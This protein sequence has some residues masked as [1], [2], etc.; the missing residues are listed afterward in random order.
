MNKTVAIVYSSDSVDIKIMYS[1]WKTDD[2]MINPALWPFPEHYKESAGSKSPL[3]SYRPTKLIHIDSVLL[4]KCWPNCVVLVSIFE[5]QSVT[6]RYN[7]FLQSQTF[8]IMA[9]NN[10]IEVP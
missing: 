7:S 4:K 9:S 5:D 8:K 2:K 1:I 6:G 3:L 10:Y